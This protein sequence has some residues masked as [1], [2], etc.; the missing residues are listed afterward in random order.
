MS[1]LLII[2]LCIGLLLVIGLTAF[3]SYQQYTG[4]KRVL[5]A[6]L[7]KMEWRAAKRGLTS[8]GF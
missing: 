2:Y 5:F 7:R 8:T 3:Y 6:L 1:R 4:M